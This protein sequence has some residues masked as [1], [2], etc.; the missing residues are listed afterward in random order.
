[1]I[2]TQFQ[3]LRLLRML[4]S[5]SEDKLSRLWP[6]SQLFLTFWLQPDVRNQFSFTLVSF[7]K[8]KSC[9]RQW[10]YTLKKQPKGGGFQWSEGGGTSTENNKELWVRKRQN[11]SFYF[12]ITSWNNLERSII[13]LHDRKL[14][15]ICISPQI[16][17]HLLYCT[18]AGK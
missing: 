16:Y 14:K 4:P 1:M 15:I 11:K 3:E 18:R 10:N 2:Y 9:G 12:T 5:S 6:S 8:A 17:F 7:E 13:Y